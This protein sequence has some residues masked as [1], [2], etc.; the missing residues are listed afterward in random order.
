MIE[1]SDYYVRWRDQRG[2][3]DKIFFPS[4][5]KAAEFFRGKV[6]D[7]YIGELTCYYRLDS[8]SDDWCEDRHYRRESASPRRERTR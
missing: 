6:Y 1:P 5:Q 7:G 4:Y 3:S 2:G 8:Q